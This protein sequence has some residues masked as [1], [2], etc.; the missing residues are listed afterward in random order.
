MTDNYDQD[1]AEDYQ[2]WLA[3]DNAPDGADLLDELHTAF[4]KYVV[5]PSPEA[6]DATVLWCA[7]SHG[8]P[9]WEHAPRL[10]PI[11]PQKRCGKSRLMDIAEAVCYRPLITINASTAAVVRSITKDDPP[12][13]MVDE[14]DTLFST[15][16]EPRR[17]SGHPQRRPPT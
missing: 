13:L 7:A 9:A 16:R 6:H 14:A 10:T 4:G 5:F 15:Q 8:Q 11:S 2:R 1:Y 12:T 3:E 17:C